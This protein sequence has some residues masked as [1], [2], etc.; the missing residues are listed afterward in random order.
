[1]NNAQLIN[2]TSGEV[3]IYTP[4]FITDAARIAVG[5]WFDLDP[6]SSFKA[7]ETVNARNFFTKDDDGLSH[8]WYGNI[9]M[10]HPFHAGWKACT[11]DCQRKSCQ[12]RGHI[13]HDIPGNAD[14]INKLE[15]EYEQENVE[16]ACCIT[17]ASTSEKW[18]QPLLRRPQCFL[19]PRTNYVKADGTPYIGI[20][21]GSVVTYYGAKTWMFYNAFQ[22]LGVVK[23]P[24]VATKTQNEKDNS[25]AVG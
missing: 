5:G 12:K 18:F 4:A 25:S 8:E 16:S 9:W 1:M 22:K 7:N 3:E 20:T 23:V 11:P 24:H 6:A 15:R 21:K 17:F 10:N 19:F 14:W 13:Y 2:Q